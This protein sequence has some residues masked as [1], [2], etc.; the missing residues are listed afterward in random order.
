M[1]R[2]GGGLSGCV[3]RAGAPRQLRPAGSQ[4]SPLIGRVA[5]WTYLLVD[6]CHAQTITRLQ[7]G[8]CTADNFLRLIDCDRLGGQT[9]TITGN[10]SVRILS[11]PANPATRSPIV[12]CTALASLALQCS[13]ARTSA[14]ALYVLDCPASPSLDVQRPSRSSGARPECATQPPHLQNASRYACACLRAVPAPADCE[15]CTRQA[16]EWIARCWCCKTEVSQSASRIPSLTSLCA[17]WQASWAKAK[18]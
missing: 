13:L 6:C 3:Q 2:S 10:K 11:S 8:S 17:Y 9:L 18:L 7:A 4:L 1:C 16:A 15:H 5:F 12:C 14:R